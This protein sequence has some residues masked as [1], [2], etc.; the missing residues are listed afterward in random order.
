MA[1]KRDQAIEELRALVEE[2]SIEIAELKAHLNGGNRAEGDRASA[3]PK[4]SH[5]NG[6]LS[7][8][9]LLKV[10]TIGLATV[11]ALEVAGSLGATPALA[12]ESE[13]WDASG[14]T[15]TAFRTYNIETKSADYGYN[16]GVNVSGQVIAIE[17]AALDGSGNPNDGIG[18]EGESGSGI[19]VRGYSGTGNGV[20]GVAGNDTSP[21]SPMPG[22]KGVYGIANTGTG[23]LGESLDSS[24][25][26][27]SGTGVL[28]KSGTGYGVYGVSANSTAGRFVS[29]QG[30]GAVAQQGH[31]LTASN[32]APCLIAKRNGTNSSG[33]S[34]KYAGPLIYG[35][36]APTS[37]GGGATPLSTGPLLQ[38]DKNGSTK[39]K[40][41]GNGTLTLTGDVILTSPTTA[42][43]ATAGTHTPPAQVAGYLVVTIAGTQ[44]KL[45][46]Y[47]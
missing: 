42:T 47:N 21:G 24:G 3:E 45:P 43:S 5:G 15:D 8:A 13:E 7:R 26:L 22:H 36:D 40:V 9:G 2:Q 32:G 16:Y 46:Y 44:Y 37:G 18:V 34:Y 35:D 39:L 4:K 12:V 33:N 19:G 30:R 29:T 10:G 38:L 41:D 20:F 14:G 31:T 27:S 25:I 11:A 23:V 1:T 6:K 17:G 28:G